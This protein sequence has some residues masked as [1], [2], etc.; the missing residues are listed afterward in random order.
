M[1]TRRYSDDM[2]LLLLIISYVGATEAHVFRIGY[3]SGSK[4]HKTMSAYER[5][6]FQ[7]SGA[8]SL[9]VDQINRH[10]PGKLIEK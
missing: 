3:I 9:A 7:I 10:H 5:P 8:I 4:R 6:G 2:A 1:T